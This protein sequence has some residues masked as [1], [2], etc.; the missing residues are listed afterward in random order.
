MKSFVIA[1]EYITI[2]PKQNYSDSHFY[3]LVENA[4]LPTTE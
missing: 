1:V 2:F 4:A 3:G